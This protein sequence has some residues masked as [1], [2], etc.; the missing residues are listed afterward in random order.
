MFD[1]LVNCSRNRKECS[2]KFPQDSTGC[3]SKLLKTQMCSRGDR[4][5]FKQWVATRFIA[6]LNLEAINSYKIVYSGFFGTQE[7]ATS[8]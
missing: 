2:R 4:L 8:H 6:A 7:I 5:P 1:L 3:S